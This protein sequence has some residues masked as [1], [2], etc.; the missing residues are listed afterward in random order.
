MLETRSIT[1]RVVPEGVERHLSGRL[2]WA[3]H[4]L[5]IAG[6]NGCTPLEH[7]GPRW[8]GYVYRLRLAGLP[9]ETIDECHAAPYPGRHARYVLRATI[10]IVS[11]GSW[12]KV[13]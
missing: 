2:A 13:A 7:P 5:I 4:A 11:L 9:I 8:S 3:L 6:Q 12:D 1:F 10:E